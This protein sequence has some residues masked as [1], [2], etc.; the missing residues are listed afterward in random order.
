[1]NRIAIVLCACVQIKWHFF[2]SWLYP[3]HMF[4]LFLCT[5]LKSVF[6]ITNAKRYAD[7]QFWFACVCL[8]LKEWIWFT[9]L[10]LTNSKNNL[11]FALHWVKSACG[12]NLFM[13]QRSSQPPRPS[14]C[15]TILMQKFHF[16]FKSYLQR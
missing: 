13:F 11:I 16:S 1:M 7:E 15:Y 10:P 8:F 6:F 4:C 14:N 5:C 3:F 12:K 9:I 2:F